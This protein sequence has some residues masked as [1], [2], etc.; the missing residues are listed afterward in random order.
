MSLV[1][2]VGGGAGAGA[3]PI[4]R[5]K[6]GSAGRGG[7]LGAPSAVKPDMDPGGFEGVLQG[8]ALARAN[9]DTDM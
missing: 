7:R 9:S 3:T 8:P 5:A 1:Y 6:W 2:G 4:G